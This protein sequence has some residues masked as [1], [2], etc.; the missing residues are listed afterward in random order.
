MLIV[1]GVSG[2]TIRLLSR[3]GFITSRQIQTRAT[4]MYNESEMKERFVL[5]NYPA[6]HACVDYD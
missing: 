5:D 6:L 4:T 2:L 1:A 3:Y